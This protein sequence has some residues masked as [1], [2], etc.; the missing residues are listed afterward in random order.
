MLS[1]AESGAKTPIFFKKSGGSAPGPQWGLR[2][3]TPGLTVRWMSAWHAARAL[4]AYG[5]SDHGDRGAAIGEKKFGVNLG[6]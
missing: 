3:Q 5:R 6:I 4:L 2:P 1:I